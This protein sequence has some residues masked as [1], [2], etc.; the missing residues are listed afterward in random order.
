MPKGGLELD[1][2][3]YT[4]DLDKVG[5]TKIFM[6][7]IELLTI[8]WNYPSLLKGMGENITG[9]RNPI[10]SGTHHKPNS[11]DTLN[12]LV[13]TKTLEI[14]GIQSLHYGF[15]QPVEGTSRI[16]DFHMWRSHVEFK[17]L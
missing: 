1:L 10:P 5:K 13:A 15:R 9:L 4:F 2:V 7:R 11:G 3:D 16:N 14:R 8:G 17:G 12:N 6:T